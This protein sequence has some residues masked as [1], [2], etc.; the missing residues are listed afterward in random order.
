MSKTKTLELFAKTLFQYHQSHKEFDTKAWERL[1]HER[2]LDI[3]SVSKREYFRMAK[4]V[5]NL[6]RLDENE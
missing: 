3:Y 6:F 5:Y 1:E 2:T 4:G